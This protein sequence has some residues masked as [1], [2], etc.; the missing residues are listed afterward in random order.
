MNNNMEALT[1]YKA[2][3]LID[4]RISAYPKYT[5]FYVN[6]TGTAPSLLH[7]DIDRLQFETVEQ[8]ELVHAQGSHYIQPQSAIVLEKIEDFK[9]FDQPP[10]RFMCFEEQTD[11]RE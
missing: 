7:V 1:W 2:S 11:N 10:R 3:N 4:C 5:D 8:F 6:R 9:K